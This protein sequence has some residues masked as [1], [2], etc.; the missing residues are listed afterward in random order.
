MSFEGVS[1]VLQGRFQYFASDTLLQRILF[2]FVSGR[3][4]FFNNIIEISFN[5]YIYRAS[6]IW[7]GFHLK[8]RQEGGKMYRSVPDEMRDTLR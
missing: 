5:L 6:T 8:S 1:R 4:E 3:S 2:L 7:L